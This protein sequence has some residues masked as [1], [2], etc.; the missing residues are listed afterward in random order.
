MSCA[1][2]NLRL[3]DTVT[4]TSFGPTF[5]SEDEAGEFLA[6]IGFYPPDWRTRSSFD[7]PSDTDPRRL[8][9]EQVRDRYAEFLRVKLSPS[10]MI[11]RAILAVEPQRCNGGRLLL[12]RDFALAAVLERDAAATILESDLI[13]AIGRGTFAVLC[14]YDY[15]VVNDLPGSSWI[16]VSATGEVLTSGVLT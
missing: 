5:K 10:R 1:I 11:Q 13:G 2:R 9:D 4:G 15:Y 8:S 6:F 12:S 7:L 16:L 14:G 3:Y